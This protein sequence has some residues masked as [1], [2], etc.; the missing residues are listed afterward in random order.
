MQI[1]V[2]RLMAAVGSSVF[3]GFLCGYLGI[4]LRSQLAWSHQFMMG[5]KRDSPATAHA[6]TVT[7][8]IVFRVRHDLL[9]KELKEEGGSV[10]CPA[11]SY[12]WSD[13]L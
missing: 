8:D 11:E 6:G 12:L 2:I 7:I 10:V 9:S 1:I 13:H 3:S 5:H 4:R